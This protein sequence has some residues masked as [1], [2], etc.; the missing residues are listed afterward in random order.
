MN[1]I[2]DN[3][4]I[5]ETAFRIGRELNEVS[6]DWM[7]GDYKVTNDGDLTS[8]YKLCRIIYAEWK[9]GNDI[10][11]GESK[12]YKYYTQYLEYVLDKY[13]VRCMNC[14]TV[15]RDFKKETD[16]NGDFYT[17]MECGATSDI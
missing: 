15:A 1:N 14:G 17:C 4:Y 6:E 5:S 3:E 8:L 7:Y 9:S 11:G 12:S 2:I 16:I 10:W 13:R